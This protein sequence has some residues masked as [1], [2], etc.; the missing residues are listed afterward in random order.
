MLVAKVRRIEA[1]FNE[2][3]RHRALLKLRLVSL[4]KLFAGKV[5]FAG[6]GGT[7]RFHPKAARKLSLSVDAK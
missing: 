5:G 1:W 2:K 7:V 6:K 4:T 3:D